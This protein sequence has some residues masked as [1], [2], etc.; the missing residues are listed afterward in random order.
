MISHLALIMDGNRRWAKKRGLFPWQGHKKGVD[1]VEMAIQFCIKREIKYL[2]LYTFSLENVNRS[3]TEKKYLFKLIDLLLHR[4]QEF[5]DQGIKVTFVG[6]RS[7][8][9][10]KLQTIC[11]QVEKK[12][13]DGTRVQCNFL[14][15][16]GGRQEIIAAAQDLQQKNIQIT[17]DTIRDHL[18]SGNIPDPELIV[19]TGGYQRLSNFLLFQSAYSEIFFLDVL[20]PDLQSTDLASIVEKY[21]SVKKNNGR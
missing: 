19:R 16:Y 12:T 5:I 2:S 8:M 10:E 21:G 1:S 17:E 20:W 7:A 3:D 4:V 13:E 14:F 11:G 9:P 6:D 15:Y 18:W